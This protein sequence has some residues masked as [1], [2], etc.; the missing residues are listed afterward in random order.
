MSGEDADPLQVGRRTGARSFLEGSGAEVGE[1]GAEVGDDVRGGEGFLRGG[2]IAEGEFGGV[3]AEPGGEF[4][5]WGQSFQIVFLICQLEDI[6]PKGLTLIRQC[7]AVVL[8]LV[9]NLRYGH[10][11]RSKGC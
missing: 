1:G 8:G 5:Y 6:N 11:D 10:T 4:C 3:S 9:W 2:A 7:L